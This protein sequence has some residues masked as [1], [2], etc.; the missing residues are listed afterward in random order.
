MSEMNLKNQ[1][2]MTFLSWLIVLA[3]IGF[4]ALLTIKIVPIYLENYTVKSILE[5]LNDEPLITQK[6]AREV[7][8]MVIR[9][10]DINGIYDLKSDNVTVKKS[11]GIMDVKIEYTVQ[12]N[13]A[14]NLDIVVKFADQIRLVAN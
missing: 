13:M 8:S 4:F 5:S 1:K 2:G 14:G 12:K 7:K 10:I 11:P 3:L 6:T 9:R